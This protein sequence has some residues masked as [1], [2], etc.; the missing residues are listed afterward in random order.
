MPPSEAE[1][2]RQNPWW[3][4]PFGWE[5]ADV[6][7]TRLA[8]SPVV[9][10]AEAVDQIPLDRPA[11]HT[12]RG[13]RQVGKSTDLKLLVRRALHEGHAPRSICYLSLDVLQD[14][15]LAG[16]VDA[17]LSLSR[18]SGGSG[19]RLV[20]LDEVTAVRN[21][22]LAVKHAWDTGIIHD[23]IVVC[24]GSSAGD[25]RAGAV[26]RL[27]GRR[28][29]GR[30]VLL[31]PRSFAA[32]AQVAAAT[33][34]ESPGLS[35]ARL[36]GAEGRTVLE[37]M[38]VFAPRLDDLLSTYARFGGL[39]AAV[40]EA[41]GG[42]YQPSPATTRIVYDSL[43]REVS[44]RGAG[45]PATVALLERVV[46]SLGAKTN[47][48]RMAREMG[49]PMGRGRRRQP[50]SKGETL[51]DYIELLAAGYFLLVVYFWRPDSGSS[52][53]ANDKKV[54]FAD[55]LLHTVAHE[56]APGLAIDTP[57]LIEN[58][59]ALALYRRCEPAA[60]QAETWAL[61][62]RLHVW[63][64]TSGG[65]VDL[66]CGLRPDLDAVEVKYQA[67]PD[68]RKAGGMARG[69]PGRPVIIVTQDRLEWRSGYV[70]IPAS[71][72]LWALG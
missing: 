33:V 23:D 7:L 25:L 44:R 43:L 29:E 39:P 63:Q 21:W 61:P 56:L 41:A 40:A 53:L 1:I 13:P 35:P 2:L 37:E 11:I 55:P 65:E 68:L 51:R 57:A 31:L 54:Y 47:W 19:R 52:A 58:L 71:L 36:A 14:V 20:L 15:A 66:V 28:D 3:S 6:H 22:Q 45:E 42:A 69:F 4:D 5:Q 32:F 30:D 50:H 9:L 59:V 12:V 17:F 27:P 62:D 24:T 10:P 64:T 16:V 70:L 48:S 26:E 67:R 18:L 38:R 46:R 8:G 34:P 49:V 60:R 72:L